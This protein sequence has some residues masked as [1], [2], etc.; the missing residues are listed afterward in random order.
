MIKKMLKKT[1]KF[2]EKKPYLTVL[3]IIV[4]T[5]FAGISATNVKSQTAFDKMLP[6]DD[7]VIISFNEVKD[8][9]G[10]GNVVIVAIKLKDSDNSNKVDDIRDPRVFELVKYLKDTFED[11]DYITRVSTPTDTI[12]NENNGII[13]NDIETVK[14]IYK[15]LPDDKKRGMY[16]NDFSMITINL[17]SDSGDSKAI[18]KE[19]YDRLEGAPV[20]EGVEIIPTGSPAMGDLMG[21][22][23]GISQAYTTGLGLIG[24]LIVLFL[25]FK[26]P[27]SATM[28]LIPILISVVWT[29][30][31]MGLFGIPLDMATAG[32]GSLLLG[33]GIDY[34][35]HLMHRYN[36]ERKYGKNIGDA[37]EIAVVSTGSAVF[38]TTATTIAGFTALT[39]APLPMMAN[40]GKVCGLGIFFCMVAVMTLLP[41]LIVIEE[42]YI[43][44][45]IRKMASTEN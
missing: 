38:A 13:P 22:L 24:V 29:G 1:A 25:Y 43:L 15:N 11:S 40:L 8:E 36:E 31:A 32:M 35:I 18:M 9:F 20:P 19:V 39:F 42:K 5:I 2:S 17:D 34:G 23:M 6:Q 21:K 14:E 44:P 41:A 45:A 7:P 33:M 28:P 16:N 12:V 10:G 4:L 26:K 30:G 37:L 27:L 3:I